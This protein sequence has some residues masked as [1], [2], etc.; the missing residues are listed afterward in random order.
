MLV[1]Q[2]SFMDILGL[3]SGVFAQVWYIIPLLLFVSI[4]KSRWFKGMFGEFLVNRLL[5]QL[6]ESDYTLVKDITLPTV[7]SDDNKV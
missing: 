5:S 6:P 1:E 2:G 4:F 7:V 3:L